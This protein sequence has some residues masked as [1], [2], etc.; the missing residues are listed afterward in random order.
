M[1]GL[2]DCGCDT[3]DWHLQTAAS[4]CVLGTRAVISAYH[5]HCNSWTCS[6]N[7]PVAKAEAMNVCSIERTVMHCTARRGQHRPAPSHPSWHRHTGT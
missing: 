5:W 7:A 6:P 1:C 4:D 3:E 2:P